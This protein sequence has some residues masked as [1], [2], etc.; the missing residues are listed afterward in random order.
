MANRQKI[1]INGR[2][3]T[4]PITGVQRY[5]RELVC[6]FDTL[7]DKQAPE[8]SSFEF[9]ILTPPKRFVRTIQLKNIPVRPIGQ[10][11]GQTWEQFELPVAARKGML[12]CPGNTAPLLSV[13]GKTPTI[14]TVHDLSYRY[15][16]EAYSFFFRMLY[17]I[18]TP[19]IFRRADAVI[20]VSESE[21]KSILQ[22]YPGQAEKIFAIQNGGF[23]SRYLANCSGSRENPPGRDEAL[24][25]FVGALNRRKNP[26]G[27]LEA[28][29]IITRRLK[30]KLVMVGASGKA[31]RDFGL[32]APPDLAEKI[33]FTGQVNDTR[34]LIRL[35]RQATCLVFTSFYEASPLPPME[36]MACG[37]PV[38]ASD[39]PSLRER[40]GDAA[41][42]CDPHNP[43]DIAD[44]IHLL[45]SDETLHRKLREKGLQRAKTFTWEHCALQTLQVLARVGAMLE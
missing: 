16:P 2:F 24:L 31:F 27:V 1:Y 4:Q 26:Q 33:I 37:C 36:A 12:F 22:I 17:K 29:R 45:L 5:A 3:L 10:F 9:E 34:E 11:S 8:I 35:Y 41:L 7:L 30:A 38:I 32:E 23:G 39:I 28:F 25:L 15:F 42:Y 21:K 19:C 14:V 44:K 6:E 43:R 20:T 40:C 13:Y 18:L